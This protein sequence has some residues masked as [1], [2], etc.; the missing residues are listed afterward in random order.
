[1]KIYGG[2]SLS[3]VEKLFLHKKTV[4]ILL[5]ILEA[6]DRE[7]TAYPLIISKEVGSPYSYVSKVLGELEEMAIV[8]SKYTGR[9][10]ILKLTECGKA[11]AIK[12]RE[13]RRELSKDLISRKK[14]ALLRS[15]LKEYERLDLKGIDTVFTY[16]PIKVE[17]ESMISKLEDRDTEA[18]TLA[19]Q[20]MREVEDRLRKS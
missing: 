9:T 15:F 8:E 18:C 17:L 3:D 4:D 14:L 6:E 10:R 12:L 20:L 7:E 2:G 19:K 16:A 1:M 13:L 5:R 11:I